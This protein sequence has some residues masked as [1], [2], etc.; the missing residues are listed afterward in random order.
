MQT[1]LLFAIIQS[2]I[3]IPLR[4]ISIWP[5]NNCKKKDRQGSYRSF[6]GSINN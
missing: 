4:C 5:L 1:F 6:K 3:S 2:H